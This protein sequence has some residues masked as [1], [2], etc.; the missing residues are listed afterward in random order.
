MPISQL[1]T[2]HFLALIE[3]EA[4]SG[5]LQASKQSHIL[6]CTLTAKGEVCRPFGKV[7]FLKALVELQATSEFLKTSWQS[8][9]A[10]HC[11]NSLQKARLCVQ[12]ASLIF[13]APCKLTAKR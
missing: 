7:S 12:L 8:H 11:V 6:L 1:A 5:A 10:T 4:E 3:L 13:S 2:A 9:I